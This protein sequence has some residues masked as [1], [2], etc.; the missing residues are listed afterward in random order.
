M[1]RRRITK[2]EWQAKGGLRNSSLYRVQ[3]NGRWYYYEAAP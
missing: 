3:R 1:S 2:Q